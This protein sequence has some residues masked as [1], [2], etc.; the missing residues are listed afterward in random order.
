MIVRTLFITLVLLLATTM[1]LA[2]SC[3]DMGAGVCQ[4]YWETPAVFSGRVVQID[5]VKRGT[6]ESYFLTKKVK[7]AVIDAFRGVTGE[8]LDIYTGSGGGDCGYNFELNESYLVYA[9][10]N[11][12]KPSTGICSRTRR[13]TDAAAD[14][15]YIRG[16][17]DAKPGGRVYGLVRQYLAQREND[18][19]KPNPSIPNIPVFIENEKN[20]FETVTDSSGDFRIDGIPAGKYTVTAKPPPGFDT[21]GTSR[22]IELFDK[23]CAIAW[24]SFPLDTGV[25]GLVTDEDARAIK[26]LLELIPVDQLDE[27]IQRDHF[28]AESDDEG[29]YIFRTVPDG[30]YYLGVRLGRYASLDFPYPRTFYPGTT[31]ITRAT[32]IEIHQGV[33]LENYDL[34]LP[35]KFS[36]RTISGK[37]IPPAG[38]PAKNVSVCFADPADVSCEGD[39]NG[40][41]KAD[42]SFK[43]TRF[44]GTK[45]VLRAYVKTP[46]G[47]RF[48]KPVTIP[49]TGNVK[50]LKLIVDSAVRN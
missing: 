23:G 15:A 7:F 1:A 12:G 22:K 43:Y 4:T 31:D 19:R 10:D 41:I 47:Q 40:E 5:D 36:T 33:V 6:E 34:R 2:C 39:E 35:P 28:Y 20:R 44:S 46:E 25:G 16:L 14:L 29:K 30:K 3:A 27:K 21:R 42:G 26:I 38:I 37:I 11:E 9:W 32:P 17:A 24:F 49:E 13:L 48:A 45:Y 8:T 18:E 50:G